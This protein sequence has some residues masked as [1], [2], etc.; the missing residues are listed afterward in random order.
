MRWCR[1]PLISTVQILTVHAWSLKAKHLELI[2]ALVSTP[3]NLATR[4]KLR[5]QFVRAGLP[6]VNTRQ[7]LNF[8]TSKASKASKLSTSRGPR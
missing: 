6:E 5:Q 2:H 3:D 8:C 1:H 4:F 7:Y